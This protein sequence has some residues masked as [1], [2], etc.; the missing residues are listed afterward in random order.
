MRYVNI[1]ISV[2][3]KPDAFAVFVDGLDA[4]KRYAV[5]RTFLIDV[6]KKV[7]ITGD[8]ADFMKRQS[9]KPVFDMIE[10]AQLKITRS[11]FPVP[12]DPVK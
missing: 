1:W 7:M 9:D 6:M 5:L 8:K 4:V 11:K 2:L 3:T 10:K 12:V